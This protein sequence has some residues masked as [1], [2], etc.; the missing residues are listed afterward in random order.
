M[1]DMLE[2]GKQVLAKQPFS[3]LVG[4]ELTAFDHRPNRPACTFCSLI[5]QFHQKHIQRASVRDLQLK[6]WQ[7]KQETLTGLTGWTG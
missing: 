1:D 3:V 5:S 6:T 2:F 4:A 7:K